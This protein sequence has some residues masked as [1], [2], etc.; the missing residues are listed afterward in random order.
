MTLQVE[1][2]ITSP[3]TGKR[4]AAFTMDIPAGNPP[5]LTFGDIVSEADN[6]MSADNVY[7]F[8]DAGYNRDWSTRHW[9]F[10]IEDMLIE[11]RAW[12]MVPLMQNINGSYKLPLLVRENPDSWYLVHPEDL[13][14]A[15][16][17]AW[18]TGRKVEPGELQEELRSAS[19]LA[20][21]ERG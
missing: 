7:N 17:R 1:I 11:R 15:V 12:N 16:Y 5:I 9:L 21:Q 2:T 3:I 4:Y 6:H 8:S 10:N 19:L 14:V 20:R 18:R 13:A